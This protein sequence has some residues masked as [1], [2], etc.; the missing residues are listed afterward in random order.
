MNKVLGNNLIISYQQSADD[1]GYPIAFSVVC[2]FL[3]VK[4]N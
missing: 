1:M 3:V 2:G 4:K